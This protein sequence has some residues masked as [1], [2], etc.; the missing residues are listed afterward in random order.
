MKGTNVK[1]RANMDVPLA[2]NYTGI[3]QGFKGSKRKSSTFCQKAD[4]D[5][6]SALYDLNYK[7]KY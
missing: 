6:L 1:Q 5:G 7:L 3:P 2:T 4:A